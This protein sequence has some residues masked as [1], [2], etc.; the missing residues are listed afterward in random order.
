MLAT[1]CEI[2]RQSARNRR[3]LIYGAIYSVAGLIIVG[4]LLFWWL[5]HG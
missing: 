5:Q 3:Y 4:K 2:T 1:Q